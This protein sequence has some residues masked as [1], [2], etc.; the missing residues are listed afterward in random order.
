MAEVGAKVGSNAD[1]VEKVLLGSNEAVLMTYK[2]ENKPDFYWIVWVKNGS[3]L[4]YSVRAQGE[5]VSKQ[6]LIKIAK[7]LNEAK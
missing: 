4:E 3:D 5:T 7:Q 6:E 2:K 1:G